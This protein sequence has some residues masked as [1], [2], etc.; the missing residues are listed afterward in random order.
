TGVHHLSASGYVRVTQGNLVAILD[1]AALGP[2]YIPGH[3][4]ADTLSFER[5][6]GTER[7]IVNSGTSTYEPGLLRESQRATSAH[8]TVEI[9]GESSSDV[10]GSFRVG[11]RARVH[12]VR[13]DQTGQSY[14]ITGS[15]DGYSRLPGRP[16]HTRT[17]IFSNDR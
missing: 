14:V 15:H 3:A 2:D 1:L 7:I 4:H 16:I 5:S 13:I 11:R 8:S 17:W 10:W 12:G 6:L 9:A